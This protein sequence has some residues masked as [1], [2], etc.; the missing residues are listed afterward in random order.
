MKDEYD[1]THDFVN[2]AWVQKKTGLVQSDTVR[3]SRHMA[4]VSFS[5]TSKKLPS[6]SHGK[7]VKKKRAKYMENVSENEVVDS[8]QPPSVILKTKSLPASNSQTPTPFLVKGIDVIGID[9]ITGIN[10]GQH[11]LQFA[12]WVRTARQEASEDEHEFSRV[13]LSLNRCWK[14][15]MLGL[16]QSDPLA[17][18]IA[19]CALNRVVGV[20]GQTLLDFDTGNVPFYLTV[21]NNSPSNGCFGWR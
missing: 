18:Y 16:A 2:K 10:V 5:S 14:L 8:S 12:V 3:L 9:G 4:V 20:M 17:R 15:F 11:L 13:Q 21:G 19:L 6:F 1:T 7:L